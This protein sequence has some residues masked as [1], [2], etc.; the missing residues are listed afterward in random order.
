V[1][2]ETTVQGIEIEGVVYPDDDV[3]SM[4]PKHYFYT[5]PRFPQRPLE[6]YAAV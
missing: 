6:V 1:L 2:R 4:V 5:K 3:F